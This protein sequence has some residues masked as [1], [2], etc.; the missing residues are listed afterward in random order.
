MKFAAMQWDLPKISKEASRSDLASACSR[1]SPAQSRENL[2][3]RSRTSFQEKVVGKCNHITAND[4]LGLTPLHNGVGWAH[5]F[6][7]ADLARGWGIPTATDIALVWLTARL[8][9]GA[10]HPVI[11]FLLLAIADDAIGLVII[12]IFYPDPSH[13]VAPAWLGVTALGMLLALALRRLGIRSYWPYLLLC[14]TVSWAGL[15]LT[16]LHPALAMVF[17]VP[18]MPPGRTP[19]KGFFEEEPEDRSTLALFEHYWK[20]IVDFGLFLFGLSNAGVPLAGVGPATWIVLAALIAGKTLGVTAFGWA[21]VRLGFPLPE[22]MRTGHLAAAGLIAGIGFTVAIFVSGAAFADPALQRGQDGG[23]AIARR[24]PPGM[25]AGARAATDL[26]LI[27]TQPKAAR[28]LRP[29]PFM[30]GPAARGAA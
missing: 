11:A 4:M 18:F 15:F 3:A 21:A 23:H 12:A 14:G 9:F 13:P 16:H 30:H 27:P 26:S 2:I 6:G 28:L 19:T 17:I 25:G 8:I 1:F 7:H 5:G 24:R 10:G 20:A 29:Q 22:G